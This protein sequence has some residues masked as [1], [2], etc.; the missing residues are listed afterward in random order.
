MNEKEQLHG[1]T[2][3]R[4][5]AA[6]YVF[7][8][9]CSLR[10]K[11]EMP[12]W[13]ASFVHNGAIG[14]SFFF[15]LSGFVLALASKKGIRS[16]YFKAR[17][18]RIYPAYMFM[19]LLTL[20]FLNGMSLDKILSLLVLFFTSTQSIIPKAFSEWNFVG[21]WSVSVEMFFYF[22]FPMI[23]PYIK[24]NPVTWLVS[25]Y[26]FASLIMPITMV[27]AGNPTFPTIY[28]SP[29][30]R[31]PEFTMGVALGCM[32]VNGFRAPLLRVM[33]LALSILCLVFISP[34]KNLGWANNNYV[35]LL[36]VGYLV[37]YL[38]TAKIKENL[39]SIPFIY[40][41]KISYSFY[42][43]QI[44]MIMF[45]VRNKPLFYGVPSWVMWIG[46]LIVNLALSIFCYHFIEDRKHMY[47]KLQIL[48][49][50]LI[51]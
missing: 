50:R 18:A 20:P 36:S 11:L 4:F 19:G 21:S 1:L 51:R 24:K 27:I 25:S 6:F 9:H 7:I 26:V 47:S 15:V 23:F 3:F 13:L 35:T 46:M 10:Y 17:I 37:I 41:G 30:H 40:F 42:L 8:F 43:M 22:M 48:K 2:I 14:M 45:L 44:P 5:V 28:S 31:F 12:Q 39:F 34:E 29:I 38:A 33:L 32:Y 16:D 49:S